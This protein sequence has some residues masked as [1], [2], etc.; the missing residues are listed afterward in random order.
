MESCVAGEDLSVQQLQALMRMEESHGR[1]AII[2]LPRPASCLHRGCGHCGTSY[3]GRHPKRR[4]IEILPH[5]KRE[6][7]LH[8]RLNIE[9]D[10]DAKR[11][12]GTMPVW[13]IGI[14]QRP[15]GGLEGRWPP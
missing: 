8:D 11:G 13:S 9:D 7:T 15:A 12:S 1:H 4:Y 14:A 5:Q 6:M 3:C 2:F 10:W